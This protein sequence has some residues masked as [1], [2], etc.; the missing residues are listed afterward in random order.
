M[1]I[2]KQDR[3]WAFALAVIIVAM[4]PLWMCSGCA[5]QP[6]KI[7]VHVCEAKDSCTFNSTTEFNL[8]KELP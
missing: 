5:M 4:I 2:R 8:P 6:P 1:I 7:E 3:T